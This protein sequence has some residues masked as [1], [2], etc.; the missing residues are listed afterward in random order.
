M[1]TLFP[2]C[3]IH[4][5]PQRGAEWHDIR[6]DKLTATAMG[7]WLAETP[8][9]RLTI[10]ELKEYALG[11]GIAIKSTAKRVEILD[12]LRVIHLP[13]THLKAT[14]DARFSAI[15]KILGNMSEAQAPSQFEMPS[16][17]EGY[18]QELYEA[19]CRLLMFD[20]TEDDVES[21]LATFP[22]APRNPAMWAI[23]NGIRMEPIARSEFEFYSGE[24]LIE[25]GFCVHR[26][27]SAGCS[28]DGLLAGKS[29]G[30]EGKC[31]LPATHVRYLLDGALP[32][33]YRDQVHGSMAVTGAQ[34]WWFQSYCPGLPPFRIFTPRDE[35]TERMTHGLDEFAI[36]LNSA[37]EE[38]A[39]MWDAECL[40]RRV[41]NDFRIAWRG[42]N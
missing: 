3:T 31:P 29:F 39:A 24:K 11:G 5:M 14:T 30:F 1:N 22:P 21:V 2:D 28:P 35:Y 13:K 12:A 36:H 40:R 4:H 19:Q 38:I 15:C 20:G 9:I 42:E 16:A 6:K 34:G 26:S 37:R 27:G 8:E 7:A 18:E 32:A 41:S 10:P 25:V 23:W 33:E 17:P